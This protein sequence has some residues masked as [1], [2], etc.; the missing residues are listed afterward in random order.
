ME[1]KVVVVPEEA[2]SE[3]A[4]EDTSK[5]TAT[6]RGKIGHEAKQCWDEEENA[7]Q[8]QVNCRPGGGKVSNASVHGGSTVELSLMAGTAPTLPTDQSLLLPDP[9]VR[10]TDAEAAVRATPHSQ[11]EIN[12]RDATHQDSITV[13]NRSSKSASEVADIPGVTC[14]KCGNKLNPG[15]PKDVTLLLAGKFN[16]SGQSKMLK[17][18]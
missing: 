6:N 7:A 1:D 16:L 12:E 4:E 14:N 13:G 15:T 11:G 8:K 2:D 17:L 10:I 3:L 9:S 5:A 18:E